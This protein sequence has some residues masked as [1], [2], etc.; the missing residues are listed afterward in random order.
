MDK[1]T[2]MLKLARLDTILFS[3]DRLVKLGS[4]LYYVMLCY[5]IFNDP[6]Y[7]FFSFGWNGYVWNK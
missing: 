3:K 4:V 7:V 1:T 5:V 6:A 2:E